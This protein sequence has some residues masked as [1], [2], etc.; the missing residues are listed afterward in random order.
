MNSFV[1]YVIMCTAGEL[2]SPFLKGLWNVYILR[3]TDIHMQFV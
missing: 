1:S 2:I 3:K